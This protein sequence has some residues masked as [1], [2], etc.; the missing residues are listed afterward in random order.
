MNRPI[1][2][3][4][5]WFRAKKKPAEIWSEDQAKLAHST[6]RTYTVLVESINE[7]YCFID[8]AK[9][10]V[11]V[12]VHDEFLR[13]SLTH[14]FQEVGPGKLF[15]TMATHREFDGGSDKVVSGISYLFEQN[16]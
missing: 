4:K 8:I 7:P 3:F 16:G 15:L 9:G 11:G 14:A 5:S 1:F 10:V 2:F 13:E 12:G 6:N